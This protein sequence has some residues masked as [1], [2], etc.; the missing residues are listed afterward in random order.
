[1]ML[2]TALADAFRRN[3]YPVYSVLRRVSPVLR[4]REGIWA[5]FGHDD[6]KRALLDHEAYSS[7]AA[8]PGSTPLD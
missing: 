1:M 4:V 6:V 5:L 7:R 3:P 8:V 2:P